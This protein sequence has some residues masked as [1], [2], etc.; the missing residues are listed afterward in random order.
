MDAPIRILLVDD[1]E[2]IRAALAAALARATPN[3][4]GAT[5]F[6]AAS[7]EEGLTVLARETVDIVVSDYRMP[8]MNGVA[9][10]IAVRERSPAVVRVLCSG[11][12]DLPAMD[13]NLPAARPATVLAKPF[14]LAALRQTLVELARARNTQAAAP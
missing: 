7:G 13:P 5:V 14:E 4:P 3:F 8:G 11:Y 10:L 12:G 2:D 9:F 1:E 6:T